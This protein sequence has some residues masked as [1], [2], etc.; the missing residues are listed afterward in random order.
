MSKTRSPCFRS[1]F[2]DE[3]ARVRHSVLARRSTGPLWLV[4]VSHPLWRSASSG[5]SSAAMVEDASGTPFASRKQPRTGPRRGQQQSRAQ[6]TRA[7][8]GTGAP[9]KC[10]PHGTLPRHSAPGRCPSTTPRP[11]RRNHRPVRWSAPQLDPCI[12]RDRDRSIF[13]HG[14]LPPTSTPRVISVL[15]TPPTTTTRPTGSQERSGG[16]FGPHQDPV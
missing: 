15:V 7:M 6:R 10:R 8:R 2:S 3:R 9:G 16:L 5:R 11:L 1:R 12:T 13:D 14:T 4:C